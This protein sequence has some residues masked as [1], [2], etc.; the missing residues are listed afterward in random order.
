MRIAVLLAALSLLGVSL[1]E[2]SGLDPLP[3]PLT[4]Q[5]ALRYASSD[6]PQLLRAS[7]SQ[8][9][10]WA[11]H[12][13]A[14]AISGVTVT[15]QGRLRLAETSS[16][17]LDKSNNDSSATLAVRKRLYDFGYSESLETS[18]GHALVAGEWQVKLARQQAHL[19]VMRAFFDVLLADLQFARDNEV[20]AIAYINADRARDRNELGQLSDVDMLQAEAESQ[21]A[22]RLRYASESL[23]LLTRSRLAVAMGRPDD[24]ASELAT[25]SIRLPE[26]DDDDF[27]AFWQQVKR[28]NPEL[29]A[30][31][32]QRT[33][34][35]SKLTAARNAHGPVLSAEVD[36]SWYNR[37]TSS[38]HPI[39][40]GLLLEVPLFAGGSREAGIAGAQA[41]V[42][43]AD[44]AL[45]A[46]ML[47]LRQQA[48]E[49]WAARG[50]LRADLAAYRAREEYRDLY[51]DRSRA[52][53]ELEVKTDLGDAMA[54]TSEVRLK[55]AGA[56][57]D[58]A[59]T[60][61][62]LKAMTGQLLEESR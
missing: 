25:P 20:M 61:A 59:M 22:R 2:G 33:A 54:V 47:R 35:R 52:L 6:V 58:W 13:S 27:A 5:D 40:G 41:D 19:A 32:A 24:L 57:F 37:P 51:L 44:A 34:A 38:T 42:S 48:M 30:L 4:L 55:L 45:R 7:A 62:R 14:E 56:L 28:D 29:Q 9:A 50:T 43:E 3:H 12:L 36:A 16:R 21:E 15:A 49:L 53:Y 18:A 39:A 31:H 46:T 23:Q 60:E 1:A 8:Q 11:E 17:S 26:K 10:A